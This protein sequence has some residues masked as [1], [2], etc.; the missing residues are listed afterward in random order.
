MQQHLLRAEGVNLSQCLDDTQ[1]LSTIRGSSLMLLR[2]IEEVGEAVADQTVRLR[3]TDWTAVSTGASIG[4]WTFRGTPDC[5][6]AVRDFVDA[7]LTGASGGKGALA[8]ARHATFVVDVVPMA[9]DAFLGAREVVLAANR[10]RQMQQPSVVYPELSPRVNDD[11]RVCQLD[12]VRPA[13][14]AEG[15]LAR[16][17][18]KGEKQ[19]VSISVWNRRGFGLTGKQK[20]YVDELTRGGFGLPLDIA[21]LGGDAFARHFA[22]IAEQE[23]KKLK[24]TLRGKIAVFYADGNKVS[25]LQND[26]L[27]VTGNPDGLGATAAER[28]VAVD[29]RLKGY[30]RDFLHRLLWTLATTG[31][32]GP[33]DPDEAKERGADQRV[34]RLETLLW[35]GDEFMFV[36]PARLGFR[37]AQ[38]FFDTT[39]GL[40]NA[41]I[42]PEGT[43]LEEPAAWMLGDK[44]ITHAAGLVFCHCDAPIARIRDIAKNQLAEAAKETDRTRNLLMTMVLESFDH[45]GGDMGAYWRKRL[46]SGVGVPDPDD[47]AAVKP[48]NLAIPSELL[49][50]L[51]AMA[52]GLAE[53]KDGAQPLARR[54]LR[55]AAQY[56]HTY[57]AGSGPFS[58]Q[59]E[60]MRK[61]NAALWEQCAVG[62]TH[63]GMLPV[64]TAAEETDKELAARNSEIRQG[65]LWYLLEELWDYLTVDDTAGGV[66]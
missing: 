8:I 12:L 2:A 21:A 51:R 57:G 45:T 33:P 46:P 50:P 38:L 18:I 66:A 53:G 28:Q 30:R 7:Q 4:L 26:L 59:L 54:Q 29:T 25:S 17:S 63:G 1:D 24:Q 41:V 55:Q 62:A 64:R 65:V 22:S 3:I 42:Q 13:L 58:K 27:K 60:A 49:G 36:M 6:S 15:A 44:P 52:R 20:F 9:N 40:S 11:Q 35:G 19:A 23:N 37:V 61:E 32:I 14:T 47:A 31:G 56:L 34:V 5:A 48:E 43:S 10:W 39:E 16:Q